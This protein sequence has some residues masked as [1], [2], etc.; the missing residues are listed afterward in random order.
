MLWLSVLLRGAVAAR[1]VGTVAA[2][3]CCGSWLCFVVVVMKVSAFGQRLL[4]ASLLVLSALHQW[5]SSFLSSGVVSFLI[6]A[7]VYVEVGAVVVRAVGVEAFIFRNWI[8][9]R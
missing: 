1:I 7:M 3:Y 5:S 8:G 6:G 9:W 2:R 4:L